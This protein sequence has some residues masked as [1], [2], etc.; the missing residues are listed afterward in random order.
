MENYSG[1]MP[2]LVIFLRT[3]LL[4]IIIP[5]TNSFNFKHFNFLKRNVSFKVNLITVYYY[6]Y[7][8]VESN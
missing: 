4:S 8:K 6:E 5:T 1:I 2:L 7:N 3:S